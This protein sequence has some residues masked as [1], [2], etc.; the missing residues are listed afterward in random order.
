M[1]LGSEKARLWLASEVWSLRD[2][3]F[4]PALFPQAHS[5]VLRKTQ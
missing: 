5:R 2:R 4:L 3:L 1:V